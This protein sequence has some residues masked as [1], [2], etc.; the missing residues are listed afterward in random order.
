MSFHH[1]GIKIKI[2]YNIFGLFHRRIYWADKGSKSVEPKIAV[3]NMDGSLP[4]TIHSR[5]TEVPEGLALNKE[6]KDLFW[7]DSGKGWVRYIKCNLCNPTLGTRKK[8][9][10]KHAQDVEILKVSYGRIGIFLDNKN[11]S[12]KAGCWIRKVTLYYKKGGDKIT[13][14][15][16]PLE[17]K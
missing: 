12:V 13:K 5:R 11:V 10:I 6:N 7:S 3:M 16:L 2:H 8:C 14:F 17:F 9:Q 4:R 1:N 15:F